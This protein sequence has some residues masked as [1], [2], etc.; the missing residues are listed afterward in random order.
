MLRRVDAQQGRDII[1]QNGNRDCSGLLFPYYWPG[2]PFPF[3]YRIRRD[4]PEWEQGKDGRLKANRKYLGPPGGANRLY[5][6]PGVT[7]EQINDPTIP[8]VITEGEKKALALWRLAYYE[9]EKPRFIPIAIAGV[10]NWRGTSG[11]GVGPN[12]ERIDIKGPIPDLN[13]IAWNLRKLFILFDA[14]VIRTIRC[15]P[16]EGF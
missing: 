8:F 10:W 4:H 11:K 7:L 2:E 5:I 3:N 1:G 16:Q 13:R 15:S 9:S 6:P 14:D 12:G